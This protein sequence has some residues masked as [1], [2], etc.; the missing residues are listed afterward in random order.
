MSVQSSY[1][2]SYAKGFITLPL[3][4]LASTVS[5][6]I[7]QLTGYT[8]SNTIQY[9]YNN[10][11]KLHHPA[12]ALLYAPDSN[13]I[14][15]LAT[16]VLISLTSNHFMPIAEEII[17]RWGV[18]DKLLS[19]FSRFIPTFSCGK[20]SAKK[21]KRTFSKTEGYSVFGFD[22]KKL[23]PIMLTSLVFAYL[24]YLG[25]FNSNENTPVLDRAYTAFFTNIASSI[26]YGI[27]YEKLGLAGSIGAHAS[28]NIFY[29]LWCYNDWR[30]SE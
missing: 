21:G 19:L 6:S 23:T 11:Q 13:Q 8:S 30:R 15:R 12:A 25:E 14:T 5:T 26:Y 9:Y 27:V 4:F 16:H 7:A 17:F 22:M 10:F 3:N 20:S 18:Q 29:D 1:I 28:W 24:H 2:G